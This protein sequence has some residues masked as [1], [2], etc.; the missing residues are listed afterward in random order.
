[1]N[2]AEPI[3]A[4]ARRRSLRKFHSPE[5]MSGCG[6]DGHPLNEIMFPYSPKVPPTPMLGE[7]HCS[8]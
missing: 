2:L 5:D 1:M 8:T 3:D 6:R 7:L 4:L